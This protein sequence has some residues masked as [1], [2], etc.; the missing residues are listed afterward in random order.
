MRIVFFYKV[1]QVAT[2][3]EVTL[4]VQKNYMND[5]IPLPCVNIDLISKCLCF[6]WESHSG[7]LLSCHRL[8]MATFIFRKMQSALADAEEDS[9]SHSKERVLSILPK[10]STE[11]KI[12]KMGVL[13]ES[14]KILIRMTN[15][16]SQ[17]LNRFY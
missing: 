13:I 17:L 12:S 6:M 7:C 16:L 2:Q 5:I 8:T 10:I 4:Y 1:M 9:Q 3:E 11:V 15:L 14:Q